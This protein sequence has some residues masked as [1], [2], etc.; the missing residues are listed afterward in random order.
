MLFAVAMPFAVMV[1]VDTYSG[2]VSRAKE[3][4]AVWLKSLLGEYRAGIVTFL[5]RQ[6]WT[7]GA[8]T[9]LPGTGTVKRLPVL[10][11]HGYMCNHRI[12]DDVAD[13]LRAQGHDVLAVDLEPLF[14]S[15]DQYAPILETAVQSLL[16]HSGQSQVAI[17]G[18]SMGGLAARAWL[19]THGL[20]R[21][22]RVITLGTPHVGTQIPQHRPTPNGR[23]MASGSEW[24]QQ[25]HAT[26]TS[27]VR[28]LFRIAITPQD[29][30]VYP[31]RDQ[32]LPDLTA[33]VF[34]GIGHVQM[35][36]DP[37]VIAWVKS[38]LASLPL[39]TAHP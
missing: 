1:L 19:R 2:V 23:Q 33:E 14:A 22:A 32:I 5:F 29:N 11:V 18:H 10:L 3:P 16:R 34:E 4:L 39:P 24:L 31:Q 21:V 20:E 15:I 37:H 8:P 17:V 36:L 35:C 9:L 6:P 27:E 28:Q 12:W 26:E 25:L 38:E 30:I 7:T 13:A